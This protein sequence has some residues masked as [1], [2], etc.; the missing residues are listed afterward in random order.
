VP[1][2]EPNTLL[3]GESHTEIFLLIDWWIPS[4]AH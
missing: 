4:I 1:Y 3:I 2:A